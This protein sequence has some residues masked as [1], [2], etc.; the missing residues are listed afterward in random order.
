MELKVTYTN[1]Q[2]H[3]TY[4]GTTYILSVDEFAQAKTT[5]QLL[6][7]LSERSERTPK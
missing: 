4:N 6:Q 1:E 7:L 2:Y 5:S 3:V